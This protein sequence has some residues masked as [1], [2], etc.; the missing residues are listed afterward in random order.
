MSQDFK[1]FNT[2]TEDDDETMVV[3][4]LIIFRLPA[5]KSLAEHNRNWPDGPK[6]GSYIA[7]AL[8]F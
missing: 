8:T 6:F 5:G 7:K 3:V 1:S 2:F 4:F